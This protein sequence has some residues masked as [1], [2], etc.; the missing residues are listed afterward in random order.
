MGSELDTCVLRSFLQRE[1]FNERDFLLASGN[2]V[3][4]LWAE[5]YLEFPLSRDESWR[6]ASYDFFR[7]RFE[8]RLLEEHDS[9][10]DLRPDRDEDPESPEY[11]GRLLAAL[12]EDDKI[13]VGA[14]VVNEGIR[15]NIPAIT[16][17]AHPHS[18]SLAV[19][20]LNRSPV[21]SD[22][23]VDS[24]NI[25]REGPYGRLGGCGQK[26]RNDRD[27]KRFSGA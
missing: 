5:H 4:Q 16:C 2:H 12:A 7:E 9:A 26:S 8:K 24:V 15:F 14:A 10:L 3:R 23:V 11:K 18:R 1:M 6:L 20:S 27:S 13:V 21:L 19:W 25:L 17:E 22:Q